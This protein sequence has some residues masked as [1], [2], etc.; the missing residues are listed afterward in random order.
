MTPRHALC[1]VHV[2][3]RLRTFKIIADVMYSNSTV[4]TPCTD[5]IEMV[6]GP[7]HPSLRPQAVDKTSNVRAQVWKPADGGHINLLQQ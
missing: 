5:D 7:K 2:T 6:P 4:L 3:A 1:Y